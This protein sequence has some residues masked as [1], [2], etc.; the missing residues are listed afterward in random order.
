[1][2]RKSPLWEQCCFALQDVLQV[3]FGTPSN[4]GT[5]LPGKDEFDGPLTPNERDAL[6]QWMR[7]NHVGEVC[8]QAL[9]VAKYHRAHSP[10]LK[11]HYW[12]AALEERDHLIW[13]AHVL[14]ELHTHRSYLN[15][16]WYGGAYALGTVAGLCGD[17]WSLGFMA[18]TER[19]VAKHLQDHLDRLPTHAHQSRAVLSQMY[20]DELKHAQEADASG[21]KKLPW[22]VP[23]LMRV[24]A[25]VMKVVAARI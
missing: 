6:C 4:R 25:N 16:F 19:Q 10:A 5:P 12:T 14:D 24:A 2:R 20:A 9:Y 22:P 8:A 21:G 15:P 17:Q 11:E 13:T 23:Q 7:I 18:E 1:M 3:S